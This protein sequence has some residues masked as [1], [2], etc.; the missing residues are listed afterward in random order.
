ME[1]P[2]NEFSTLL[3]QLL[4]VRRGDLV[5][6]TEQYFSNVIKVLKTGWLCKHK[7][8][9]QEFY[10]HGEELCVRLDAILSLNNRVVVPPNLWKA[11]L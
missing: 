5:K 10:E 6:F 3:L 9:V 1:Q 2:E 4:S 11:I 8:Q 7:R